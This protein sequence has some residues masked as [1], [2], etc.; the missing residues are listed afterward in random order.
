VLA[1]GRH[2]RRV[3]GILK[4]DLAQE[5][6]VKPVLSGWFPASNH[7]KKKNTAREKAGGH[8]EKS[9]LNVPGSSDVEWNQPAKVETKEVR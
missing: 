7:W 6:T 5:T 9:E 8:P 2:P 3:I 4:A 1:Q